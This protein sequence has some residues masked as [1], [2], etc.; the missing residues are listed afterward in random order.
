MHVVQSPEVALA[1]PCGRVLRS[2]ELHVRPDSRKRKERTVCRAVYSC[3][4]EERAAC[5]AVDPCMRTERAA[6]RALSAAAKKEE[7]DRTAAAK[8]ASLQRARTCLQGTP[9]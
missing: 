9:C 1:F 5:Y 7:K 2:A 3:K 4:H 6:C 8:S